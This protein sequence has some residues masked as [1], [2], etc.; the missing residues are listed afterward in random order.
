MRTL[1]ELYPQTTEMY[2]CELENCPLCADVLLP[3][4][5]SSGRKT[6]QTLRTVLNIGYWP[7]HCANAQCRGYQIK[8]KSAQWQH[9]APLHGT[10]GYDVIAATGW[11]RQ[12]YCQPFEQIHAELSSQVKISESQVRYLYY[13]QYL[14]LLA[15]HERQHLDKLTQLSNQSGLIL[16]L[17]GLA[18]EGGEPQLWVI[19]EL[20]TG[21]TLR[22][23]WLSCQ[24]Q[25]AFEHFL[26]PIANLHLNIAAIL[27]DK[28]RGL[29]PAISQIFPD[30]RHAFCQAHYLNNIAEPVARA[31]E[32]MKVTLRKTIRQNL[33][34]LIRS[35]SGEHTGVLTVTG[36]IPSPLADEKLWVE[37]KPPVQPLDIVQPLPTPLADEK[38]WVE[39][40]PPV[41][42]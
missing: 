40:K 27:S 18:P 10:Y 30:V 4:Q 20:H 34:D 24:D 14:P 31:D 8:W 5:Y 23:G 25:S 16:S 13:Y 41:Q 11:H 37:Q 28:Q 19:R 2:S 32:A 38:L 15:C 35:E 39:Q 6:V 7:K 42:P 17:D 36:L 33:G 12:N 29:L 1:K 21:L 3:C 22:S 26:L 9:I